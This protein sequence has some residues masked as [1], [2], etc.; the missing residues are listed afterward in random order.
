[1][2]SYQ[3]DT[4]KTVLP[5]FKT[6]TYKGKADRDLRVDHLAPGPHIEK[7]RKGFTLPTFEDLVHGLQRLPSGLDARGLTQCLSWYLNMR[8]SF[9]PK[10][11][12]NVL[13]SR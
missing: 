11:A 12:L 4:V 9:T 10:L 8:D 6:A 1:M 2:N 3:R 5:G 13:H 7:T